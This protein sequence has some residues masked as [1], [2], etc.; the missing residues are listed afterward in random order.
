MGEQQSGGGT[1]GRRRA[2]PDG[3]GT[4]RAAGP[5]MTFDDAA[6]EALLSAAVLRGHR[7]DLDGE[8]RA[9]AAYRA[10]RAAGAHRARTRRRDDWRPSAPRRL[11]L[12][13]KTTLSLFAASLALGGVAVAAIGSSGSSDHPADD[14]VGSTPTAGAPD[15]PSAEPCGPGCDPPRRRPGPPPTPPAP[16]GPWRANPRPPAGPGLAGAPPPRPPPAP[17]TPPPPRTPRP[18]AAPTTRSGATARPWTPRPGNGSSRR[19]AARTGWPRTAPSNWHRRRRPSRRGPSRRSPGRRGP[20]GLRSPG[21]RGRGR[22]RRPGAVPPATAR[23]RAGRT[24]RA[25]AP[26]SPRRPRRK[27]ELLGRQGRHPTLPPSPRRRRRKGAARDCRSAARRPGGSRDA[28]ETAGAATPH[29]R[30][31]GRRAARAA[32]RPVL[33]TAS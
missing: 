33:S 7:A 3:L 28:A 14:K 20:P 9:V 5:H 29:R 16:P 32:R 10:A 24:R 25:R 8:Q 2:H 18:S 17:A 19:R 23:A 12:S 30:G 4:G 13:V 11:A 1:P 15:R 27:T 26:G 31:P 22:R 21:R 6:L